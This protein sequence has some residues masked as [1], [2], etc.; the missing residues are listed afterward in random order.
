MSQWQFVIAAYALVGSSTIGLIAW[1]LLGMR[2]AEA[3]AD[4]VKRRQ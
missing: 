4:A 3:D 1:S 2:R